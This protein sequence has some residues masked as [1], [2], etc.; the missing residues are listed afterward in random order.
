MTNA[1]TR[2][3]IDYAFNLSFISPIIAI[4]CV[5]QA[6]HSVAY[7]ECVIGVREIAFD[8][9]P[10]VH[11][12]FVTARMSCNV[13]LNFNLIQFIFMS[14]QQSYMRSYWGNCRTCGS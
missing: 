8:I 7:R 3:F 10:T 14:L 12:A 4:K 5:F 6:A 1:H 13:F 9:H 11:Q 2:A